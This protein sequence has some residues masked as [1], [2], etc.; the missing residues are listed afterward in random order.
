MATGIKLET[1]APAL[2]V[3]IWSTGWIV[4][5]Y[6]SFHGDPLTFLVY[7]FIFATIVFAVF[8]AAMKSSWPK[9]RAAILHAMV[10]GFF[11]HTIYLGGV[12]WAIRHGV[13]TSIS[14]LLAVLQPLMTA[15]IARWA[16]N[17]HLRGDQK[18]GL[19]LGFAGLLVAIGPG[20]LALDQAALSA[21]LS[22]LAK[23][24]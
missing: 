13:P 9:T 6:L 15:V 14:G 7:R 4:G 16:V 22:P 8:A 5:K 1:V 20:L 11:L 18:L 3:L 24:G 10:S 21:A 19:A 2:F 17:E 12:W 23:P